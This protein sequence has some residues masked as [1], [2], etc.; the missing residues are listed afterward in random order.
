MGI[1]SSLCD[2]H[3]DWKMRTLGWVSATWAT[4]CT[5]RAS[6]CVLKFTEDVAGPEGS[7]RK[8][9]QGSYDF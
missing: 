4:I 5:Y 7:V 6:V 8:D 1:G 2:R 9:N 3:D